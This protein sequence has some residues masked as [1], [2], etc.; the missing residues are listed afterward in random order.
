MAYQVILPRPVKKQ[1][2]GLPSTVRRRIAVAL[3]DLADNP[4]PTGS[5]KLVGGED[6]RIRVGDY[7]VLYDIRDAERVVVID[8]TGPRKD[9][10]RGD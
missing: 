5:R 1:L 6:W 7:R 8:W 2:D 9:A 4:R 3:S 10:Y